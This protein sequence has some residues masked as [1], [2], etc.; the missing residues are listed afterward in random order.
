MKEKCQIFIQYI[1]KNV[2]KEII[3]LKTF[4]FLLMIGMRRKIIYK[5]DSINALDWIRELLGKKNVKFSNN[6]FLKCNKINY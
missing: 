4:F 1:F 5:L 3:E 2:I 6:I